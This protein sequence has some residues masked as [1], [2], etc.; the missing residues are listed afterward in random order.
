[1]GILHSNDFNSRDTCPIQASIGFLG[2]R[3]ICRLEQ[4]A[5]GVLQINRKLARMVS[6]EFVAAC[7]GQVSNLIKEIRC[8][9]LVESTPYQFCALGTVRTNQQCLAVAL[10]FEFVGFKKD[11]H[12]LLKCQYFINVLGK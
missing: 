7:L 3:F 2:C 4:K 5:I 10:F 6:L 12:D 1:M 11:I 9:E 8:P